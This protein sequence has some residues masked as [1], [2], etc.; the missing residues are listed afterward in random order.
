MSTRPSAPS[1]AASAAGGA[2]PFA[3]E[4]DEIQSVLDRVREGALTEEIGLEAIA[5]IV[6]RR[7][8]AAE[9]YQKP[10]G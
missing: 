3:G 1:A 5:R 9:T 7:G 2:S 10:L 8:V 6:R 4:L